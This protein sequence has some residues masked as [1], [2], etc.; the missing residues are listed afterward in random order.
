[1]C[2]VEDA[3]RVKRKLPLIFNIVCLLISFILCGQQPTGCTQLD[4]MS[5]SEKKTQILVVDWVMRTGLIG[6]LRCD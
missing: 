2:Y 5:R 1:M 6:A 3:Y 4:L